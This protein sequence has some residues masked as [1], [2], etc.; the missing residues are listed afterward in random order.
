MLRTAQSEGA[1]TQQAIL[2]YIGKR[3][4]VMCYNLLLYFSAM[5]ATS[6]CCS[7]FHTMCYGHFPLLPAYLPFCLSSYTYSPAFLFTHF[8]DSAPNTDVFLHIFYDYGGRADLSKGY[9]NPK[10]KLRVT[11]YFSETVILKST[12][13]YGIFF[14]I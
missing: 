8:K 9:W 4:D 11:M 5:Y 10:R 13:M 1:S 7:I 3:E 2:K 12:A 14:P 6:N